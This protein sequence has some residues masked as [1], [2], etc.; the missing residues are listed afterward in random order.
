MQNTRVLEETVVEFPN[1]YLLPGKPNRFALLRWA[2]EGVDS[3]TTGE[4]IT[5]EWAQVGGKRVTSEEAYD[6]FLAR[7]NGEKNAVPS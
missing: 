7:L 3:K 1:G 4:H 5:L 2:T 6:R